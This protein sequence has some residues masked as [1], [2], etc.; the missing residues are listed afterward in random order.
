MSYGSAD[1]NQRTGITGPDSSASSLTAYGCG[2]AAVVRLGALCTTASATL[3]CRVI[4]LDAAGTYVGA[5]TAVTF[6]ADSSTDEGS[7]YLATPGSDSWFPTG[8]A[9]SYQVK[10]DSVSAGTWTLSLLAF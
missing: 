9:S 3:T 8:G 4:F 6:T 10:V 1:V 5:T 7:S 2:G